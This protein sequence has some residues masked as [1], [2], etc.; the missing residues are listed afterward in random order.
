MIIELYG[1]PGSG[2]TT[3][4]RKLA[5]E[6]NFEIVKIR[7]KRDLIFYN[8]L[9]L[10]SHPVKFIVLFCYLV[11]NYN[12]RKEFYLNLMNNFLGAN[13][14]YLKARNVKNAIIDQGYFQ[15]LT[16]IS[17]KRISAETLARY[18]DNIVKPDKLIVLD[19]S[20]EELARRVGGRGYFARAGFE[21]NE[22]KDWETVMRENDK[23]IKDNLKRLGIGYSLIKSDNLDCA[24]EE[25]KRGLEDHSERHKK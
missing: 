25:L 2:K 23:I 13:A 14:K 15:G 9:F 6:S 22:I 10:F 3:L 16:S 18:A 19:V 4:A 20:D 24:F 21:D 8:L 12:G 7:T 5:A 17:R 11:I 1:L